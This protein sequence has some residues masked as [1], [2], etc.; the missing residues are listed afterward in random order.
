MIWKNFFKD[1]S[2]VTSRLASVIIITVIA[3]MVFVGLDGITYNG[4]LIV[5]K[6][7]NNQNVADYWITGN[8]FDENDIF[9]LESIEGVDKVESRVVL[10]ACESENNDIRLALYGVDNESSINKAYIIDGSLPEN[11]DEMMVSSKFAKEQGLKI[12]EDYSLKISGNE[13]EINFK[14]SGLIKN[15][16]RM[17]N[18]SQTMPSPDYSKYGFAYINKDVASNMLMKGKTNQIV[19]T[20]YDGVDRE[21]IKNQII[22]Q[23]DSRIISI[24]SLEDNVT[25]NNLKEFLNGIEPITK[26]LPLIFF[27][28]A[29]LLMVSTMSRLIES[30]RVSIG[31]LKALGYTDFKIL[32]YYFMYAFIVVVFGFIIGAILSKVIITKPLSSILF[33]LNDLPEYII[34]YNKAALVK[35]FISTAIACMGT[36]LIITGK[37]LKEKPAQCMRPKL[38]K[39]EKRLLIEKATF[40]WGRLGFNKK[41]IIK[42][43]FR[44][45]G[46]VFTCI[47]GI[48]V[49]M[50]LVLTCLGLKD[51]ISNFTSSITE[52]QHKYDLYATF[53]PKIK[54]YDIDKINE[55]KD[56]ESTQY[57]MN[58]R[59]IIS[60]NSKK[61]IVTTLV[62]DDLANLKLIDTYNTNTIIPKNGIIINDTLAE[63]YDLQIGDYVDIK[64]LGKEETKKVKISDINSNVNGICIGKEYYESNEEVFKPDSV[65]IKTSN[66]NNV[67]AELINTDFVN[68]VEAKETIT[69]AI[70]SKVSLTS[71]VVYNLI[72]VGGILAMVVLYNLGVMSFYEQIRSLATLKV[73]GFYEKEIKKL[74]LTENIIYTM[75]GVL[76]GIP[77]GN[78]LTKVITGQMTLANLQPATSLTSYIIAILLTFTFAYIVNLIIGK[79]MKKIDMLG[80][81]KSVE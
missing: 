57:N 35:A 64:F 48:T 74:Q 6:Y 25:T 5:D 31:T 13:N 32:I 67:E 9:Y 30:S 54:S 52:S 19:I 50:A 78:A 34:V 70:I 75:F 47:V 55:I 61:D 45:K 37:A 59:A 49:C 7:F 62:S 42:N 20:L 26:G 69:D 23:F 40:I 4:N 10:E 38:P 63:N 27:V 16:E 12:G 29:A 39:K 53:N 72:I 66:V 81:L 46:R 56:I 22:D 33:G 41:Y 68:D 79:M 77:L 60:K 58:T 71:L 44:N 14:I 15:P 28:I 80:A 11:D 17:H 73:L 21:K 3:V 43:T 76:I 18:I 2:N 65:Y 8:R 51:S 24:V 1:L 36:S